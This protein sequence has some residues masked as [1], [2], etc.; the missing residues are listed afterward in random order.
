MHVKQT[1]P[2]TP[3]SN[4][5]EGTIQELKCRAGQKMAKSSC[6]AKL[7]DH[8][9]ELEAYIRLHTALGKYE[10]QGQLPKTI[11]S[12]PNHRHIPICRTPILCMGKVLGQLGS[13]PR[14]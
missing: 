10:L 4:V 5:A 9:L 11:V 2:Y 6:L 3:W 1:E 7:W 13:I 8:C 12:G 14:A